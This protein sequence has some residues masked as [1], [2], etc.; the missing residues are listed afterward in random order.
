MFAG[1]QGF[2]ASEDYPE[3]VVAAN[4]GF[5]IW[6]VTDVDTGRLKS[7]NQEYYWEPG[8]NASRC[9]SSPKWVDVKACKE[10]LHPDEWAHTPDCP[11]HP[12][13]EYPTKDCSCGFY[14]FFAPE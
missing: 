7:T 14:A 12:E 9:M 8:V 5:R 4:N 6:R 11:R 10:A 3:W 2:G 1:A 13:C